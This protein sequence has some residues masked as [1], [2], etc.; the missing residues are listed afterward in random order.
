MPRSVNHEILSIHRNYAL[1]PNEIQNE[2]QSC[3]TT[4]LL[5]SSPPTSKKCC[6]VFCSSKRGVLLV[7]LHSNARPPRVREA[8]RGRAVYRVFKGS[9]AGTRGKA[10]EVGC[11]PFAINLER[12]LCERS[13]AAGCWHGRVCVLW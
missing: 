4:A 11:F 2:H 10:C 1:G 9:S 6:G 13:G 5:E 12:V 8:H 7:T 3:E